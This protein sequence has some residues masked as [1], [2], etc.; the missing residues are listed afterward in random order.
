MHASG[1]DAGSERTTS[2]LRTARG[3]WIDSL[4]MCLSFPHLEPWHFK[5]WD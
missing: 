4:F 1:T 3:V 2:T 5:F